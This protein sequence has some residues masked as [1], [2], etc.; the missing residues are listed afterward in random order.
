MSPIEAAVTPRI[1]AH[2]HLWRY[3]AA[4]FDWIAPEGPL[5][6]D[7]EVGDLDAALSTRG[8]DAAIAVQAR[9]VP[10]ETQALL[11]AAAHCAAIVGVVGWIDLRAEDIAERLA[12]DTAPLIVGYRHIVEAEPDDF[13]LRDAVVRGVR[14]IAARERTYDLLVNPRQL[15]TVPA[16]LDRVGEGRFILDHAAKPAI[17][18][19][20]WQPWAD[21]LAAVAAH[22]HVT[23]KVSGLVTEADH[24]RWAAD[25]LERYL[26][27]IFASFGPERLM[28]GSDWPVC[29]LAADYARVH[30]VIAD[31]VAR[32]C[33]GAAAAIF[34]GTALR[35][36]RLTI[37]AR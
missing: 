25:E 15:S 5:A 22:P 29:L 34:G 14:A 1:D 18:R 17:A 36:Y 3:D 24:G 16:F 12:A 10:G 23:C 6:R 13:L 19:G 9:Q 37:M 26:D 7:F 4:T 20:G 32:H 27:H 28:W 35:T 33:P 31:Y 8:I 21:Q 2:H 30:D 11:A